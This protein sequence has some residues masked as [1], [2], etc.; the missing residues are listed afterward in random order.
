MLPLVFIALVHC[1]DLYLKNGQV[2]KNCL[3]VG[4]TERAY[5][6]KT[7]D[8]ERLIS[9][10]SVENIVAA[11][12]DSMSLTVVINPDGSV[13]E[14]AVR[15]GSG[16]PKAGLHS[17]S[18]YGNSN[19]PVFEFTAYNTQQYTGTILYVLDGLVVIWQGN[20]PY[21]RNAIAT[22]GKILYPEEI[23]K[24]THRR[25]S[26]ILS[27]LGTGSL[28]GLG[29]GVVIG[30]MSG[31]DADGF[32]ALRAGTKALLLGGSLGFIGGTI[33][34]IA[35]G[36]QGID[37]DYTIAGNT[38]AFAHIVPKLK[39]VSLFAY[40]PPPEVYTFVQEHENERALIRIEKRMNSDSIETPRNRNQFH[41]NVGG[42]L[43]SASVSNH[44]RDAF[45][46]SGF[47]GLR[48]SFFGTATYPVI[49]EQ[50]VSWCIEAEY[51]IYDKVRIGV[52]WMAMPQSEVSGRENEN[53]RINGSCVEMLV[54][55]IPVPRDNMLSVRSEFG[56]AAGVSYYWTIVEGNIAS[57]SYGSPFGS[58]TVR[59]NA[60][61][62]VIRASYDYYLSE[63]FSLL[64]RCEG[65]F[66]QSI[67][68]PSLT[69][70]NPYDNKLKTLQAHHL[71][72]SSLN[73]FLGAQI[74][75]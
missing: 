50:Y 19:A 51:S 6:V 74:H 3:V 17:N 37:D 36:I 34:L 55:Y 69:I 44:L 66:V 70:M 58:F 23:R 72:L 73:I 12:Y 29:T 22:H 71:G 32:F 68:V 40:S 20:G 16:E 48:S 7:S 18:E 67:D 39:E 28:I 2:L 63:S 25:E 13:I 31:D 38:A 57:W 14:L 26:R 64:G 46:Q 33:G 41:L 53:E 21:D 60:I 56:M 52:Q 45:T 61:G 42:V 1:D 62:G 65:R 75:L 27:G 5:R 8:R 4:K 54:N 59:K 9:L 11:P 47:N 43:M 35:G 10:Y 24:I 15:N 30:L 49:S